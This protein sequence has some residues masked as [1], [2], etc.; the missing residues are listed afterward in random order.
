MFSIWDIDCWSNS[1]HKSSIMTVLFNYS[2]IWAFLIARFSSSASCMWASLIESIFISDYVVYEY[3]V[4][5]NTKCH[6]KNI[7][8]AQRMYAVDDFLISLRSKFFASSSSSICTE[9]TIRETR[10]W[11]VICL[12]RVHNWGQKHQK[13]FK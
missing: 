7:R 2:Q 6:F 10:C 12:L 8:I 4:Q 5:R 1:F 11:S 3:Y 9:I 13:L